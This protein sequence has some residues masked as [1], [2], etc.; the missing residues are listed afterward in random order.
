MREGVRGRVDGANRTYTFVEAVSRFGHLLTPVALLPAYRRARPAFNGCLEQ[1][2][3][4][5]KEEGPT[6]VPSN[7][8]FISSGTSS[9]RGGRGRG[10]RGR[11]VYR[12]R[13]PHRGFHSQTRLPVN[14]IP[15][16]VQPFDSRKRQLDTSAP[17]V[18]GTPSKRSASNILD[19]EAGRT[20][21]ENETGA[22]AM[23]D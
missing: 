6:E 17:G 4:V 2:F 1:Y 16:G 3:V 5:L 10:R 15:L 21:T 9:W 23:M 14:S 8:A 13:S 22:D 18:S 20:S 11:G 7:P 19:E 12:G